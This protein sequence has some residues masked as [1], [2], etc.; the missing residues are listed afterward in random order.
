MNKH[1]SVSVLV[2]F[3]MTW[4]KGPLTHWEMCKV[5]QQTTNDWVLGNRIID[6]LYVG[7]DRLAAYYSTSHFKPV[8]P[9]Y[10]ACECTWF[11]C[12]DFLGL[13]AVPLT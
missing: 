13:M 11:V 4:V 10:C 9:Y 1:E 3:L 8:H 6:T 2:F 12:C 5:S 7:R